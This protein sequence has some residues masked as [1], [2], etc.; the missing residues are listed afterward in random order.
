MAEVFRFRNMDKLLGE[1]YQ[2]LEG[3]TIY[4]AG[5]EELNDPMEGFQDLVWC[6][7]KIVWTNL[8]K[9]YIH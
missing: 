9:H 1:E 5:P 2:E 8:V 4:F 7:D 6:G 3:Q